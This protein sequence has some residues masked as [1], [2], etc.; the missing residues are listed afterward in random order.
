MPTISVIVPVY[1]VEKYIHRCIESI[2]A[3]TF[4]DFELILVD[5]GS[6]DNCGAICDEY[7]A[8]DNRIHV[9]HQANGG[10]SE[11]NNAGLNCAQGE[12]VAFC[13]GDDFWECNLLKATVPVMQTE[14]AD[15]ILFGHNICNDNGILKSRPVTCEKYDFKSD[16][17]VVEYLIQ[18]QLA[19]EHGW[20]RCM[21]IFRRNIIDEYH[22]RCCT[23]CHSFAEDMGFVCRYMLHVK[24]LVCI[25]DCLYNYYHREDS[26]MGKSKALVRLND[27][28]EVAW[29]VWQ[30]FDKTIKDSEVRRQFPH[31]YFMM[32]NNQLQK[33][34]KVPDFMRIP[35]EISKLR[36]RKWWKKNIRELLFCYPELKKHY[37]AH[38]ANRTMLF[39]TYLLHGNWKLYC[40]ESGLYYKLY[41]KTKR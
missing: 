10:L 27:L 34:Y 30:D 14:Q 38:R 12:L 18:T 3:Q 5:D 33:M 32:M 36:R 41:N 31:L 2:L 16:Q 6:P 17:D 37:G 28:N 23:T 7:A 19:G 8:R 39:I 13:D 21:R 25:P 35:E 4:T 15:C 29:D 40:L 26:I 20:E 9:I 11:A 24:K 22:V 1:K